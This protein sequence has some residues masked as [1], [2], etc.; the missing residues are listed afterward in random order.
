MATPAAIR[1]SGRVAAVEVGLEED[2]ARRGHHLAD[3][4]LRVVDR[5]GEAAHVEIG[6]PGDLR[7]GSRARPVCCAAG[8]ECDKQRA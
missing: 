1:G 7:R 8:C 3:A 2:P 6:G 5:G 4:A